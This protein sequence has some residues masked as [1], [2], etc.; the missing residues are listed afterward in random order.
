MHGT[1]AFVHYSLHGNRGIFV[2]TNSSAR[3]SLAQARAL[4]WTL[5]LNCLMYISAKETKIIASTVTVGLVA[6]IAGGAIV[7]FIMKKRS[8]TVPA[9]KYFHLVTLCPIH[10]KKTGGSF[11]GF[12]SENTNSA[13]VGHQYWKTIHKVLVQCLLPRIPEG[14]VFFIGKIH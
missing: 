11:R 1:I 7:Y 4:F 8:Q 13:D 5:R 2:K 12:I 9:S 6:L 3:R 14:L 10:F